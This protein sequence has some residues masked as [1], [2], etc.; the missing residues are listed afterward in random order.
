[1]KRVKR[2]AIGKR[3]DIDTDIVLFKPSITVNRALERVMD[4]YVSEG[5]RERTISDY[6]M[7]WSEFINVINRQLITDVTKDDIRKYVNHL[8]KVRKLSPVTVNI[9]L[10][11]IRAIFNRLEKEMV[12]E[13]NPVMGIRKVKV[14]E[15]KIYTLTDNQIKRLFAMVDKTSYAGY[16]DYVAMLVMLKCGL[17][18]N[19]IN[20]LEIDDV[21]FDNGVILLPGRKNKNRKSRVIPMSKKVQNELAQLV[22]ETGEYFEGLGTSVFVNSFGDPLNPDHIRKRMNC[23]GKEASLT[24]ECRCSPHSLRHTF[25]VNFLKNGGDIRTLSLILGHSDLSTTQVYL[26]YSDTHVVEQ[27]MKASDNDDL[28][29]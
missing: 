6:R 13:N 12:I 1:M 10:S 26:S 7:F 14:D 8:L 21:D 9:R 27:Y 16:R 4:I 23:Y 2:R 3:R 11:A 28:E 25:A 18:I 19:E 20:A 15:Q 5:Y 24:K 29:V 17:R 22:T